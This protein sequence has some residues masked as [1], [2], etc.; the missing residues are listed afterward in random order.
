MTKVKICGIK[1]LEDALAAAEAGADMLGFNFY[2]KSVRYVDPGACARISSIVRRAHPAVRLVGVFVNAPGEEI[3]RVLELCSLDLAQLSGDESPEFSAILGDRAFKSLHGVRE[4][5]V[6][7]YARRRAPA[8]LL[9]A[10]VPGAYGGT[11]ITTDWSSAR[12]LGRRYPLML[13]GGLKPE[14]VAEA[15]EQ[16]RPWGVDAASGVESQP[17]VK[18]AGKVRAFVEAVRSTEGRPA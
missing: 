13:A 5:E 2:R 4:A 18:D 6:E 7:S 15:I 1:R 3:L 9:D 10:G 12:I 11:G 8:F 17:G 14:N 16:V